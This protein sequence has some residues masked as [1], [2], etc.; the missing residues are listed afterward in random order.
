M[1]HC[2]NR[3][4]RPFFPCPLI[5][6]PFPLSNR[7]NTKIV[8]LVSIQLQIEFHPNGPKPFALQMRRIDFLKIIITLGPQLQRLNSQE[9]TQ[10]TFLGKSEQAVTLK[11]QQLSWIYL[12]VTANNM[13]PG[14]D[15][16]GY[17]V[18]AYQK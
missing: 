12:S 6:S 10:I 15:L 13:C 8:C 9:Q 2:V 16:L 3:K 4:E 7:G 5:L 18:K 1:A 11:S 17:C 14:Q